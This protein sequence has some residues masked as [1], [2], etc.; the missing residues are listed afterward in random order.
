MC[1][2]KIFLMIEL[3]SSRSTAMGSQRVRLPISKGYRAYIMMLE[4][5]NTLQRE[6]QRA[7]LNMRHE[8]ISCPPCPVF[9]C[10]VGAAIEHI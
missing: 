8:L 9:I 4:M 6:P 10:C 5:S 7:D 2:A 1:S 3:R